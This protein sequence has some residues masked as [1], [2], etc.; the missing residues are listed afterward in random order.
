MAV[1]L[2]FAVVFVPF[3]TFVFLVWRAGKKMPE[4]ALAHLEKAT[5]EVEPGRNR[6]ATIFFW[7]FLVIP[8]VIFVYT[9]VLIVFDKSDAVYVSP[10]IKGVLLVVYLLLLVLPITAVGISDA[11]NARTMKDVVLDLNPAEGTIGWELQGEKYSLHKRDFEQINTVMREGRLFEIVIEFILKNGGKL[12]LTFA[13]PGCGALMTMLKDVPR[14]TERYF[15]PIVP[16]DIPPILR[17]TKKAV[18][19]AI[20]YCIGEGAAIVFL[21]LCIF[22]MHRYERNQRNLDRLLPAVEVKVVGNQI[23]KTG[24]RRGSYHYLLIR[25]GRFMQWVNVNRKIY[26]EGIDK[27]SVLL[28]YNANSNR[29]VYKATDFGFNRFVKLILGILAAFLIGRIAWLWQKRRKQAAY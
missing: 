7:L 11:H 4:S 8:F 5:Y 19:T 13:H 23:E 17:V 22:A 10:W 6:V 18:D 16:V 24:G 3:L 20:R 12:Y 14:T 29:Y 26:Q 9:C 21:L 25:D 1:A 28:Y 27:G 15:L 2:V